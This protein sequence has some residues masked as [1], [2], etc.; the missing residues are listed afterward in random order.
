M[1]PVSGRP[2][3]GAA[4]RP[5]EA[6][7]DSVALIGPGLSDWPTARDVLRGELLWEAAATVATLPPIL[8]PA[9]RRRTSLAVRLALAAGHRAVAES[10]FGSAQLLSVFTSS[11]GDGPTCHLICEALAEADRRVSPTHFHNSVHNAPS[12]YWGIAMRS[13]AA[14]TSLCGY[15]ASFAAGLLEAMTQLATAGRPVILVAYD[16]PYPEPLRACR[17]VAD[18]FALALVLSPEATGRSL[19]R[20][21]LDLRSGDATR[22]ADTPLEAMRLAIPSA[23]ALPLLQAIARREE[24]MVVLEYLDSPEPGSTPAGVGVAVRPVPAGSAGSAGSTRTRGEAAAEP[25]TALAVEP[26]DGDLPR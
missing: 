17:P 23:R 4:P 10:S 21:A 18:A 2:T 5:L 1:T 19:A 7:I 9:E 13:T 16:A 6:W 8:P 26:A 11:G 3:A 25:A 22:M 24:G 12:G 14:A 15:D 20:V